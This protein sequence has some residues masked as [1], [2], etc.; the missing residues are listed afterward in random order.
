ME[1]FTGVEQYY[2][3]S[4]KRFKRPELKQTAKG[5]AFVQAYAVYEYTVREVT[6][7]AIKE[8]VAHGHAYSDLKFSVL[9]VFLEPQ[10]QSLRDCADKDVWSRRFEMLKQAMSNKTI[11]VVAAMPHDGSHFRHSQTELILKMLGVKRT[12]TVRRRHLYEIDDVVQNRNSIAHGDETAVDVG[13]R[14]SGGDVARKIR[15]MKSVCLRL[16]EIVSEH[17]SDPASHTR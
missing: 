10:M 17:C 13:R 5:L 8:I 11:D 15:V 6:R 9:A 2:R 14:Y 16:I 1:R 3:N 7:I 12:L 4:M